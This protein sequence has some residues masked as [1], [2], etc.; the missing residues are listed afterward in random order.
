MSNLSEGKLWVINAV[1][2]R[3]Q[4]YKKV[5]YLKGEYKKVYSFL[6]WEFNFSF[7]SN[8]ALKYA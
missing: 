8:C 3:T 6:N 7:Y 5:S 1:Y 4:K 2:I